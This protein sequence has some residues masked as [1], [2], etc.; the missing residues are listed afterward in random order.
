MAKTKQEAV[1]VEQLITN[2]L[3]ALATADGP[4]RLTGKGDPPALFPSKSGT[5][6]EAIERC[7]AEGEPLL[8]VD[9]KGKAETVRLTEAGFQK[10]LPHLPEDRVGGLARSLAG[11]MPTTTRVG[12]LQGVVARF[13]TATAELIPLLEEAIAAERAEADARVA[14][15]AKRREAEEASLKALERWKRLLEQRREQRIE[16]L[17]QELAVEGESAPDV[18]PPPKPTHP[19]AQH[20]PVEHPQLAA[21]TAEDKTFRRQVA[22]RLVSS[23]LEAIQRGK[24]EARQFLETTIGNLSG[25]RQIGEV[26]ES[27]SFD[28]AHHE[29]PAGFFTGDRARIVRP[30]WI[31]D[32]EGEHE[33]VVLKAQVSK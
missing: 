6:K 4:R 28:G 10:A 15:A 26:D 1:S 17:K 19:A 13:P 7:L 21:K 27:V 30:G 11:G 9:G 5:N 29:G 2:A 24:A 12:F 33:Y 14:E 3:V 20:P 18:P 8:Q 25:L 23:W 16:S 22:R 31:L 32:E